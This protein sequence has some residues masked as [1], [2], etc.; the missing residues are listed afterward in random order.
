MEAQGPLGV[1][2]VGL[3]LG[4]FYK[5]RGKI[6]LSEPKTGRLIERFNSTER[7]LLDHRLNSLNARP[8]SCAAASTSAAAAQK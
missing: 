1:L 6:T 7:R 8:A 4:A 2:W 3:G 5:L